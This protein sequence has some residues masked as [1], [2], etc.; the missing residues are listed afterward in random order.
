MTDKKKPLE[1][2]ELLA[3]VEAPSIEL[4]E[5]KPLKRYFTYG[6][7]LQ[8][9]QEEVETLFGKVIIKSGLGVVYGAP[10]CGK[11]MWLRQMCM[12][13]ATG[14]NFM[15]WEYKG[16]YCRAIY[17]SSE[18]DENITTPVVKKNQRTLHL[19]DD[20]AQ[21]LRFVFDWTPEELPT[22]IEE[23]LT[24]QPADLV[25]IDAFADAFN[26]RSDNDAAEVRKF[27]AQFK[28]IIEK[29]KC[30]L[31]FNHHVSKSAEEFPPSIK[32]ARG[33]ETVISKGRFAIE[34]RRDP[35]NPDV[36]HIC[37]TKA[38]YLGWGEYKT[39]STAIRMDENLVFIPSGDHVD[40]E[41]L[42]KVVP[43]TTKQN[44]TK[45]PGDFNN[46]RHRNFLRSIFG[47]KEQNQSYLNNHIQTEFNVSDKPARTFIEF[48]KEMRWIA[49]AGK[50]GRSILY[51]CLVK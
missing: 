37:F 48:Y 22:L 27:Y 19:N 46:D 28:P 20:A 4:G 34:L 3:S 11:S 5:R 50:S 49:E 33:S 23:L 39:R 15:G 29:H 7:L 10:D 8:R 51:K 1:A 18:D 2:P 36:K 9:Q 25:V 31:I 12:H 17:L 38:N 24:E 44:E 35:N 47:D 14:R 16:T 41:D 43:K 32:N 13:V 40:F 45:K 26:G 6:D 21:N 42:V 30:L